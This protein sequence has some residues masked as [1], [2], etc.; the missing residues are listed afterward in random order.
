MLACATAG[1]LALGGT[2]ALFGAERHPMPLRVPADKLA[3]AQALTSP[4]PDSSEIVEKGKAL[5][6]GKG[7]CTNCHGKGGRGDGPVARELN[8]SPRN[9]HH[10]GF[11]RHRTEGEIFWVIKHGSPGTAMIGFGSRL[12]DEEAWTVVRYLRTFAG[13]RGSRGGMDRRGPRGG[14]EC[15]AQQE[16]AP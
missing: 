10:R 13:G 14:G 8:P 3:E 1:A 5:Y 16:R 7:G 11:W 4:L 9:F 15:C 2:G 12:S 6:E